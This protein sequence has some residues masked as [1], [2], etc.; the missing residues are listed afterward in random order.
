[1]VPLSLMA[2]FD[3]VDVTE[4]LRAVNKRWKDVF[5]DVESNTPVV[6]YDN[7]G[8]TGT[9]DTVGLAGYWVRF[10]VRPGA[11]RQVEMG[12][13]TL[14]R[15]TGIATAQFFCPLG[16]GDLA[17]LQAVD[18]ARLIFTGKTANLVRYRSARVNVVGRSHGAAN[19]SSGSKWWQI[20][21]VI[22]FQAD[23]QVAH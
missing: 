6:L 11:S 18:R 20:N 13:N 10:S 7:D 1:M 19:E 17:T 2:A 15:C 12:T 23:F 16:Q 5:I 3:A 8:V 14:H 21:L 22:P 9:P 4:L